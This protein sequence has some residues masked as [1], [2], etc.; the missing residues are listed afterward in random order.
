MI[1]FIKVLLIVIL[2]SIIQGCYSDTQDKVTY[3]PIVEQ[4]V[5]QD[6]IFYNM[7]IKIIQ[8]RDKKYIVFYRAGNIFVMPFPETDKSNL[9]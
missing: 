9:P 5:V 2:L 6:E 8:I 4:Y 1:K 3:A 7:H